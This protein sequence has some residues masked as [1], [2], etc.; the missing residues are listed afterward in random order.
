[1][2]LMKPDFRSLCRTAAAMSWLMFLPAAS[3]ADPTSIKICTYNIRMNS[4]NDGPDVWPHRIDAVTEFIRRHDVV[5]LQ[6]VTPTQFVDLKQRLS[7]F[8]SYGLGRDDGDKRGEAAAVFFRKDRFEPLEK[9][10]LWLSEDPQAVGAKSWDAAITRTMTWIV[11]RDM[12]S[13]AKFLFV[14]THFDHVGKA[15]RLNSAIQIV[16]VTRQNPDNLPIIVMG[17]FNCTPDAPPYL[18]LTEAFR[19]ARLVGRADE[20]EPNS[21]WNGFNEIVPGRII[22][23]IFVN[24]RV[25]VQNFAIHNPKTAGGRFASDHLPV[26]ATISLVN[27]P[28]ADAAR[29]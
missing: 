13:D 19:D 24:D 3:A 12:R 15:A 26:V 11:F 21:T 9:M 20:S 22:D 29:P 23:H 1:M 10:T 14:N 7:G 16:R 25:Q 6:E 18:K 2:T 4:P 28:P 8:D 27:P 5:G 17:D